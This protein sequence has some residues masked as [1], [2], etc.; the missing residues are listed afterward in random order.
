MPRQSRRGSTA[1]TVL[2]TVGT[3]FGFTAFGVDLG[4]ATLGRA[5]VQNALDAGVLGGAAYFDGTA[6]GVTTAVSKAQELVAENAALG[7]AVSV[8]EVRVGQRD[9]S[10]GY[11]FQLTSDPALAN[12]LQMDGTL[13]DVRMPFGA[14]LGRGSLDLHVTSVS[15]QPPPTGAGSEDCYLPLA[16]PDCVLDNLATFEAKGF[17]FNSANQ[18][19]TGWATLP[20]QTANASNVKEQIQAPN[21]CGS[22]GLARAGNL[23]SLNNGELASAL[24][25]FSS[26]VSAS[27]TSW[28]AT[29]WGALPARMANSSI[30]VAKYGR[31]IQGPIILF[32]DD[33]G[34][35]C[36]SATQFNQTKTITGFVWGVIYDVSASGGDKNI[37][38]KLDLSHGYNIGNSGG[39]IGN[40]TFPT[41]PT[42]VE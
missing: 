8:T 12:S 40:V 7:L 25:T 2:L 30:P 42:L 22:L 36:A 9:A 19:N 5:Q 13:P 35:V 39:G 33:T 14:F 15:H 11:Q 20:P 38:M 28:N 4:V 41:P 32:H 26:A 16:V 27:T 17:R 1:T 37:R 3:L 10:T 29:K 31:V 23:V 34:G 18:D 6:S 24:S 21:F